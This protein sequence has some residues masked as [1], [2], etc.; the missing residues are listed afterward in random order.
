[1][2]DEY[3]RK[4]AA[5][6][7]EI[8]RAFDLSTDYRLYVDGKPRLEGVRDF[9]E[10]RGIR[11]SEGHP[12]DPPQAETIAGLG[13]RKNE[14]FGRII[15]EAGV[16]PYEGSV[17]LIKQ[18]RRDGFKIAVVTSSENC[19][20]ILKAAK[21]HVF[22]EVRVDGATIRAH[23]L[24]GKPAPDGVFDGGKAAGG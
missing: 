17:A 9:L 21:L 15:E 6:Q 8:F 23:G 14:L 5:E 22:F 2:F 1:M 11:L 3:V 7:G 10:S 19:L 24:A 18:L 13:T 20:A 12:D 4:R 16:R